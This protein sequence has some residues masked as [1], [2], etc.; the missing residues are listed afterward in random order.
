MVTFRAVPLTENRE[1][2]G[3]NC[4]NGDDERVLFNRDDVELAA[5]RLRD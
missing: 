3:A 1:A 2:G 4:L 5:R